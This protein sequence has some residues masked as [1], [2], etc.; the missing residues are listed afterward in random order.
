MKPIR[1]NYV[2]FKTVQ[3]CF[4]IYQPEFHQLERIKNP[5]QYF[6]HTSGKSHDT[7]DINKHAQNLSLPSK[8]PNE[9][10]R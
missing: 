2:A 3:E 9:R 5:T 6:L 4:P 7:K 10:E 8:I 1:F